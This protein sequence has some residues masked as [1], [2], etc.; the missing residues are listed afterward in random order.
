MDG[1]KLRTLIYFEDA[2]VIQIQRRLDDDSDERV[3]RTEREYI[4]DELVMTYT[5]GDFSA[6]RW[7]V[8]A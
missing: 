6:K 3:L 8:A 1:S 5:Q 7:F 4:G 2:K